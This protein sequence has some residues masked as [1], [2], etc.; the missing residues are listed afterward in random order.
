MLFKDDKELQKV[1]AAVHR[2]A[3]R[4]IALD[5]T[6]ESPSLSSSTAP[7]R[8]DL[9]S[10]VDHITRFGRVALIGTGEHGVGVGKKEYLTEEL[11]ENTVDL[12]R[13]VKAAIDPLGIMNP[14]K[15][16]IVLLFR[17][18]FVAEIL[19]GVVVS[20][21]GGK[22][23]LKDTVLVL[24]MGVARYVTV[25]S[26]QSSQGHASSD[27]ILRTISAEVSFEYDALE[28]RKLARF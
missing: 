19:S 27:F 13:T 22:E 4:A 6:C 8:S 24:V 23:T 14:G 26:P 2:L 25:Q 9:S 15:V 7:R 21:Y 18:L 28:E 3:H 20:G 1:S 10:P 17:F 16:R 12:M 11:G 5:G